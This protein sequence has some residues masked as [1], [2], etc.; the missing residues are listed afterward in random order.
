MEPLLHRRTPKDGKT[1]LRTDSNLTT[2]N[3]YEIIEF[4][5]KTQT[6]TECT[7]IQ[8]AAGGAR[9]PKRRRYR[10]TQVVG[11][12]YSKTFVSLYWD[13]SKFCN[14]FPLFLEENAQIW[15][16]GLSEDVTKSR[17]NLKCEFLK[18]Y[19]FSS[20]QNFQ[21][22]TELINISQR[23]EESVSEYINRLHVLSENHNYGEQFTLWKLRNECKPELMRQMAFGKWP[24]T[25]AETENRLR[26]VEAT[27]KCLQEED[28]KRMNDNIVTKP[29]PEMEK[30]L[31]QISAVNSKAL[32]QL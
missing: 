22:S 1:K 28:Q 32:Q 26:S 23:E 10:K 12:S 2:L 20:G 27:S 3:M 13:E 15:Y 24:K 30:M 17:N 7:I 16:N 31:Q 9:P 29:Q 4:L 21:T 19:K 6:L 5:K 18:N 14:A 8:F 25:V 11:G